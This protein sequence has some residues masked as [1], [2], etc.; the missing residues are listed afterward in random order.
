MLFPYGKMLHMVGDAFPIMVMYLHCKSILSY[1][2][3]SVASVVQVQ[4]DWMRLD[5]GLVNVGEKTN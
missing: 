3:S 4:D 1:L 2:V 5:I